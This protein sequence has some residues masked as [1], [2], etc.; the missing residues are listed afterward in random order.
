MTR[1]NGRIGL[2]LSHKNCAVS[3]KVVLTKSLALLA[4]K[5]ALLI[6]LKLD[7]LCTT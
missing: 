6:K 2:L 4:F 5:T 7:L 3:D 1:K